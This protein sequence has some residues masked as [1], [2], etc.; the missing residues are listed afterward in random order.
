[1]TFTLTPPLALLVVQNNSL[2]TTPGSG[3]PQITITS[4]AAQAGIVPF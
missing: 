1:V 2:V 3:V 4:P